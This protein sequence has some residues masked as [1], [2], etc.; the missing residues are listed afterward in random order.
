V[1]GMAGLEQYIYDNPLNKSNLKTLINSFDKDSFVP[2]IGAGPS[3]VLGAPDWDD[4]ITKLC[5]SFSLKKFRKTKH[6]NKSV[7]YA[8]TFSKLFSKLKKRGI[9]NIEFY[10][11]LFDCM[12][13]TKTEATWFHLKLVKLFDSFITTNYDS[14]IEKAFEEYHTKPPIKYFFSC[15]GINNFTGCIV[16][17][18]G[19]KEINFCIIKKEDYDYFYPSVSKKNGIPILE[20]FLT[21][22]FTSKNIIFVG[23]SFNDFYIKNFIHYLYSK[24]SF[25]KCHYWILSEYT[26]SFS[27]IIERE[28][29]YK[30]LGLSDKATDEVNKFF[31][32][33]MNIKPIVYKKDQHIFVEKLF[34]KLNESVPV[35]LVSGEVSG[36]PVR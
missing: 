11:K 3:T 21:E 2:F 5:T 9:T 10:N 14:P 30:R 35:A 19:H 18:H 36:Q 28:K 31:D 27:E 23:F 26:D 20:E 15:Y 33:K 4:L 32:G 24:E 16:Y 13:P 29:E 34:E 7:D 1:R 25:K 8:K 22:I 12:K 6:D 17:L